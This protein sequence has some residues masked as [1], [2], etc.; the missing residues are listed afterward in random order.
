MKL[1]ACLTWTALLLGGFLWPVSAQDDPTP[2][3]QPAPRRQPNPALAPIEADPNLP[4]VLLIGDSISIGYTLATRDLL[5]GQANVHRIPVNG[6]PTSR[7]V[8][9]IDRWLGDRQWKVIHFNWGLHDLK[10][11]DG[12]LQVSPEDYEKNLRQLVERMKK[13]GAVLIWCE[14]TPVPARV[15]PGRTDDDVQKYNDIAARI[16]EEFGVQTDPLY[17]YAKERL[18]NIQRPNN[19]HFTPEGSAVLAKQVAEVIGQALK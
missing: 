10:L 6:G 4:D 11:V 8:E 17:G 14:T 1:P 13:T 3:K 19:V 7:G 9:M 2:A 16:M 18:D 5:K 15:N 12:K